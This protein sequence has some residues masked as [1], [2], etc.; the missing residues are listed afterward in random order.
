MASYTLSPVGGAAAQ[1]FD[2]NGNVLSG[3]KLYVYAAGT[4]TPLTTWTTPAG[5]VPNTNPIIFD[6]AGRPPNEIWLNQQNTYKFV[7]KTSAD[8]LVR[9]YDN[10][11]GLP[12]PPATNSST[13]ITYYQGDTVAASA[14]VPGSLYT[15]ATLG[16][17][18]FTA[19]GAAYNSTGVV[20]VAT[21]PGI[22]TGTAYV[23]QYLQTKLQQFVSVKDFGAVGDG[24]TDDTAAFTAGVTYLNT[25]GGGTLCVPQ[26]SYLL[27]GVA[28]TDGIK[29]GVLI[30]FNSSGGSA[31]GNINTIRLT[32][33]SEYTRLIAG[34]DNMYVVRLSGSHCEVSNLRIEAGGRSGVTGLGLVPQNLSSTTTFADQSQNTIKKLLIKG[35][36]DAIVLQCGPGTASTSACYYNN[37]SDL[38]IVGAGDGTRGIYLKTG[39]NSGSLNS[40][41]NRNN[42][43]GINLNTLNTGIDIESGDTNNFFGVACENLLAGTS[44]SAT[45]TGFIVDNLDGN[46]L[47]NQSNR[48]F[49]GTFEAVTRHIENA[50]NT[51]ELYGA[52]FDGAKILFTANPLIIIG[53]YDP[54]VTP[55]ILPGYVYQQNAYLTGYRS[56]SIQFTYGAAFGASPQSVLN[57]YQKGTWTPTYKGS[58][59]DPTITYAIQLG[60]YERIGNICFINIEIQTNA[61]TGGTGN[62]QIGDLPFVSAANSGYP[63]YVALGLS[64]G[65]ATSQPKSA[66]IASS[67]NKLT[68]SLV[69]NSDY[70]TSALGT[71]AATVANLS[72]SAGANRINVNFV[73]QVA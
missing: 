17:T 69:N 42:F 44:P 7:I 14:L 19:V 67:S 36:A 73:Y 55:Q 10:I 64:A 33:D 26:G 49:G 11:P 6:A 9:T 21:A 4:T 57:Y 60:S 27:N 1:F 53:G 70:I 25:L 61:A 22:G 43:Y 45:P 8:V 16:S 39:I 34:S 50:N 62:L 15:I 59:A 65:F 32:G 13:S 18:D 66:F 58:T 56:G 20:F 40:T 23:T 68:L 5:S 72:N 52:L 31:N 3:G 51:T 63:Q 30:P 28:G 41:C 2:D 12:Q 38:H 48:I 54:S 29:N 37:F 46:G 71:P 35:C 24:V 47:A